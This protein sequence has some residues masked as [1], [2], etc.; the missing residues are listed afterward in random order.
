MRDWASLSPPPKPDDH[1]SM[2]DSFDV[3]LGAHYTIVE[4]GLSTD[5]EPVHSTT[6]T[7]QITD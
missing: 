3:E 4:V 6:S 7:E 2:A 1:V 5:G